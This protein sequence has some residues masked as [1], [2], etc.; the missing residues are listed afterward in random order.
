MIEPPLQPRQPVHLALE[1][2]QLLLGSEEAEGV[3]LPPDHV[4]NPGHLVTSSVGNVRVDSGLM[5]PI[6]AAECSTR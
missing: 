5:P 2:A 4:V 3:D 1:R 6:M